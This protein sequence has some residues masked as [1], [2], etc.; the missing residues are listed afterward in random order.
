MKK[1]EVQVGRH[2]R[3][4]VSGVLAVVRVDAIRSVPKRRI[5]NYIG[6]SGG[7]DASVYD[8]TNLRTGR[9]TTFRSAAKLRWECDAEGNHILCNAKEQIVAPAAKGG[10]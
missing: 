5:N 6:Q 7:S 2:Y 1:S 4:K 8:V 10:A 9:K 3:A